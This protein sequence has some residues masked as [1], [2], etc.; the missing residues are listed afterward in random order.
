MVEAL[1][2]PLRWLGV[3]A[4]AEANGELAF[5]LKGLRSVIAG[6]PSRDEVVRPLHVG[7]DL[8]VTVPANCGDL[9]IHDFLLAVAE[10]G[11]ATPE[12]VQYRFTPARA[13]EAFAAGY[14]AEAI[15][16]FL[17]KA[18]VGRVPQVSRDTLQ[19][20]WARYGSLHLYGNLTL[21]E[22]ADDYTLPELVATS[23]LARRLIYRFSPRL[24]AVDPAAVDELLDELV[25]KGY[26]PKVVEGAE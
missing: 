25:R 1:S 12:G 2:G 21:V 14:D 16:S 23:G 5:C 15:L 11:E 13:C 6:E 4:V 10:A 17:D 26:T 8:T 19:D 9:A 18:S 7:E 20:W 22:F 3:A 24:I